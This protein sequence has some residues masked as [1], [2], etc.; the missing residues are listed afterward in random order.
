MER[1]P[2]PCITGIPGY[3]RRRTSQVR[4]A[5]MGLTVIASTRTPDR[6][7]ARRSF[8]S[9]PGIRARQIRIPPVIAAR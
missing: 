6:R 4:A 1:M 8:L 5:P 7:T 9:V 2:L 3:F